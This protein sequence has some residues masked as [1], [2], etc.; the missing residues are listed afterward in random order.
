M[1][2][3]AAAALDGFIGEEME[4][5]GTVRFAHLLRVDGRLKGRVESY[6]TLVVGET[7]RV[8]AEVIVGSLKVH[9]V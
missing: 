4:V 1:M 6:E 7:G 3:A 5:E 9:G 2:K 8:E